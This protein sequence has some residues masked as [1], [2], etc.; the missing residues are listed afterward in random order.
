MDLSDGL[1]DAARQIAEASGTGVTLDAGTIP[2]TPGAMAWIGRDGADP[3]ETALSGGE[4][5]ELLFA[6]SP[7][8]RRA[9]LAGMRHCR[10]VPVTLVGRL[11]RD[12]G[13]WLSRD[14][15][16]STLNSGFRHFQA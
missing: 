5:Y 8:R 9:F 12:P 4:D 7:R 16:L 14:G 15:V 3:V 6:V 11:T 13:A 2:V 1:A 10:P